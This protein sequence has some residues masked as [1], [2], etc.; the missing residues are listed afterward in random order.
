MKS[1]VNPR[2]FHKFP[3][4]VAH[5]SFIPRNFFQNHVGAPLVG[6]HDLLGDQ[7]A[8]TRLALCMQGVREVNKRSVC[9][10]T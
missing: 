8:S 4:L 1:A 6:A 10:N 5:P 2:K 9:V 3:H 7:R